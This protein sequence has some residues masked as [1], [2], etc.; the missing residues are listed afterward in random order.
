M[1]KRD[2]PQ[3]AVLLSPWNTTVSV[4]VII[5]YHRA[6]EIPVMNKIRIIQNNLDLCVLS[7]ICQCPACLIIFHQFP[8]TSWPV[9]FISHIIA[10]YVYEQKIVYIGEIE[11]EK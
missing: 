2:I 4:T 6:P 9:Y 11:L 7:G 10:K 8:K 5:K 3:F 1:H